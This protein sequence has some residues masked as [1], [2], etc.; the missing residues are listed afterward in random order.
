MMSEVETDRVENSS[1]RESV[2]PRGKSHRQTET[3]VT[4][5]IYLDRIL[6]EKAKKQGLNLSRITE[7][8]VASVLNYLEAQRARVVY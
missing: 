7:Q 3:K 5:G 4:I 6:V 2:F 8:T 1:R